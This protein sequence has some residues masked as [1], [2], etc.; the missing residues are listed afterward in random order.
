M[1]IRTP[2]TT[3]DAHRYA[4]AFAVFVAR[5]NQYPAM[6]GR[7]A[8]FADQLPDGFACLDVGAGTGMVVRDWLGSGGRRPGRYLAIEPNAAHAT[9]LRQTL[10]SLRLNAEVH[11][12]EFDSGFAIPSLFDLVLFSH[13][14]YWVA[15]PVGCVLRACEVLTSDGHVVAFLQGPFG[16]HPLYRLFNPFFERDRPPGPNHGFS[17]AELVAGL[18]EAG[19][20]PTVEF[21]RT[22]LDLSGLFDAG[23]EAERNEYLSFCLQIEFAALAEPLK[24]DVVAYLRAACVEKEG[25][26]F[27]YEPTA[28]VSLKNTGTQFSG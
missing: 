24:S 12:V 28:T 6:I 16:I 9:E 8:G 1:P 14:L 20:Y 15:E 17:S 25:R 23:N 7:L 4:Q 18:R 26:L 19:I 11:E 13:S 22:A 3:L 27:W 21:D 5:S 10:R 2:V